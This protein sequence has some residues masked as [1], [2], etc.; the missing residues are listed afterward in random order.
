[1]LKRRN[2][3]RER[4]HRLLDAIHRVIHRS[5]IIIGDRDESEIGFQ[6]VRGGDI[7]G[8]HTVFLC[9]AGERIELTHR[10]TDRGIFAR[11]ALRAA[12]WMTG[13]PAGKYAMNDVLFR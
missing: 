6:V 9:A 5:W 7:V 10:A 11:G 1:M 2:R 12:K 8:E 3:R 13:K 4:F